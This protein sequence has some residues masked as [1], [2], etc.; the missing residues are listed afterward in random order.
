VTRDHGKAIPDKRRVARDARQ[1]QGAKRQ[2]RRGARHEWIR[3]KEFQN[4]EGCRGVNWQT[5]HPKRK[6][7]NYVTGARFL[8]GAKFLGKEE[9]AAQFQN[10]RN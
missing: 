7:D 4:K 8:T 9:I 2:A 5:V 6:K 3:E 1:G 10:K